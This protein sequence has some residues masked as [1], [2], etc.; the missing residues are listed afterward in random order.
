VQKPLRLGGK[1]YP[2]GIG[3]HATSVITYAIPPG[4]TRFRALAGPDD[5][6]LEQGGGQTAIELLVIA[7]DRPPLEARV[8]L[9]NADALTRALGRPN[10]EQ[11]VTQR[12]PVATTLQALE[13]TNGQ[14]LASMLAEGAESWTAEGPA[15]G[16]ERPRPASVTAAEI[17]TAL[18]ERALG[19]APSASER[20]AALEVVGSPVRKEGVEDL[21]WVMAML[22]EFQLIY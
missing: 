19:R 7:G 11:I 21:L 5:G 1:T 3:T 12:S 18:Y 17:V 4:A 13:L 10:R 6:A 14:T 16:T 9:A 22:P 15:F 8:A 2:R 20:H